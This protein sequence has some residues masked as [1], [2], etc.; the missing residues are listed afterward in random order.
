MTEP[1]ASERRSAECIQFYQHRGAQ[2]TQQGVDRA[3][4]VVFVL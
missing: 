1:R 3:T 2:K 4:H